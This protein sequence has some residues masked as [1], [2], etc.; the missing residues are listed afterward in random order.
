MYTGITNPQVRNG[1]DDS[2]RNPATAG[3]SPRQGKPAD[4]TIS[5]VNRR[6]GPPLRLALITLVGL[7]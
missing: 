3:G 4:Q 2:L 6:P 1:G 5:C 7:S